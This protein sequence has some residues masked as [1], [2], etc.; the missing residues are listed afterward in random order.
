MLPHQRPKSVVLSWLAFSSLGATL[1]AWAAD[2]PPPQ[3]PTCD[4]RI[5]TLAVTEPPLVLRLGDR[6]RA[7]PLVAGW[8]LRWR[9]IGGP[10]GECGA[11]ARQREPR[12]NDAL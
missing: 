1:T 5:G 3:I 4:K 11:Q 7:D 12:Q 6:E 10:R 8:N 9:L 2:Q